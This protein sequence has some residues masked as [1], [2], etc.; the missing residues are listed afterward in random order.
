[1]WSIICLIANLLLIIGTLLYLLQEFENVDLAEI[2]LGFGC[3][4][5]WISITRYLENTRS[6]TFINRTM[7]VS[8]PIVLRAMVGIFPFFMGFVFLGLCLFWE[9]SRFNSPS[10]AMF[11]LFAMMNGD[12]L[13]DVYTDLSYWRFLLA[14]LYLYFFVF[15]SIW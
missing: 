7:S 2:T 12:A 13:L 10:K 5:T 9:S 15:I 1:M 6:Y 4:L 11:T 3:M 8:M 14:S